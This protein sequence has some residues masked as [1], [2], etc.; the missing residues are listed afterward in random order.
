MVT[1]LI[2]CGA[3]LYLLY[4][5]PP[6]HVDRGHRAGAGRVGIRLSAAA[7]SRRDTAHAI[8]SRVADL[9]DVLPIAVGALAVALLGEND[10]G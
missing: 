5:A 3:I 2:V 8:A 9:D 4:V 7:G 6:R 10:P 1:V